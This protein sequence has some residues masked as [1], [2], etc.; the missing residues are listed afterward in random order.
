MT[1][2]NVLV[3]HCCFV[4]LNSYNLS[5]LTDITF[6][7]ICCAFVSSSS[8]V[9]NRA[10]R[11]EFYL[12][13]FFRARNSRMFQ[14]VHC[15][16]VNIALVPF[17]WLKFVWI[18]LLF[19][20]CHFDVDRSDETTT[21]DDVVDVEAFNAW[22]FVWAQPNECFCNHFTTRNQRSNKNKITKCYKWE[23]SVVFVQSILRQST[24]SEE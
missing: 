23:C 17:F 24:F 18:R 4:T 10:A 6:T 16:N 19:S 11:D 9:P 3:S 8:L 2:F 15:W 14:F 13:Q 1:S 5:T 22:A 21:I 20:E 7:S 12:I